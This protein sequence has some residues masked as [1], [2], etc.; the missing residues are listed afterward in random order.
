MRTTKKKSGSAPSRR[1]RPAINPEDREKQLVALAV[2]CAEKQLLDGTASPSVITHYLKLGTEKYK[3][4]I[5][6]LEEENKLLKAKTEAV[7]SGKR[8]E[9][10]FEEGFKAFAKYSGNSGKENLYE[11]EDDDD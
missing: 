1:T 5:A 2:N 11:F 4:E 7:Q 6:K 3:K 10:L 9:E 8:I